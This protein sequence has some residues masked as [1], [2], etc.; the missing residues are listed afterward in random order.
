MSIVILVMDRNLWNA[1]TDIIVILNPMKKSLT[2]V[3]RDI[4]CDI[5]NRAYAKGSSP[6]E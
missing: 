6:L 2:W 5:I 3:P 4:Y 1:N